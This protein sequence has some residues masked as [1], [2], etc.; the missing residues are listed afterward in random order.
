MSDYIESLPTD[1]IPLSEPESVLLYNILKSD[2]SPFKRILSE[3]RDPLIIG[4]L[5]IIMNL[6]QITDIIASIVP[7]SKTSTSAML[8]I[9]CFIIIIIW[10][11]YKNYNLTR[12]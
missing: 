5:F 6:P 2:D 10:F 7:Y 4:C 8:G 9:K 12:L 1:E 11:I 3:L